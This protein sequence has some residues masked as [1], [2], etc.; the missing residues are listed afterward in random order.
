[1]GFSRVWLFIYPGVGRLY[2]ALS[3]RSA[4]CRVARN[5]HKCDASCAQQ[6]RSGELTTVHAFSPDLPTRSMHLEHATKI[7]A[8]A[9]SQPTNIKIHNSRP[10][11]ATMSAISSTNVP[12]ANQSA[13]LDTTRGMLILVRAQLGCM[14][15]PVVPVEA[16]VPVGSGSHASWLGFKR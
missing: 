3:A 8:T 10:N 1:M 4:S 2:I 11:C 12:F 9:Q 7:G 14:A 15:P 13:G 5:V 16:L 6:K